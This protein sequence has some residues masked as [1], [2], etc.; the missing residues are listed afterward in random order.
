V[1]RILLKHTVNM[2]VELGVQG[3]NIYRESFEDQFLDHTRK[4]YQD[5]SVQYISQ[6]TCSDYLKKAE[7]RIREEKVRVENYLH[8]STMEKIQELCDEEWI[9][10][11]Y[12]TLI[13]M[14]NSGCSWMLEHD[15]VIDLER[16]YDIFSRES[17]TLKELQK[18]MID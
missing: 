16:M 6:N 2:L 5:E 1:D 11:H 14:E 12:K 7:K 4:F 10:A 15:K 3:K 8:E 9:L 17:Q 13:H 18:V